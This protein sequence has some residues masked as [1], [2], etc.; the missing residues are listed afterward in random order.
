MKIL[1]TLLAFVV[2]LSV[3]AQ[4]CATFKECLDKGYNASGDTAVDYFEKAIKLSKKTA[5]DQSRAYDG[6]ARV[7]Y[8]KWYGKKDKKN[9]SAAIKNFEKAIKLNPKNYRANSWLTA[10]YQTKLKD[11]NLA[12]KTANMAIKEM[13]NNAN[14]Y[15]NIAHV[16][17]YFNKPD[18]AY[19]AFIK[20]KDVLIDTKESGDY[21]ASDIEDILLWAVYMQPRKAKRNYYTQVEVTE[22]EKYIDIAPKSAKL[23]GELALANYDMGNLEEATTTGNRAHVLDGEKSGDKAFSAT[24]TGGLFIKGLEDF[25]AKRYKDAAFRMSAALD[26][27]KNNHVLFPYYRAVT[28]FFYTVENYPKRWKD[29]KGLTIRQFEQTLK[30]APGTPHEN[31][32]AD[33]NYYLDLINNP[34]SKIAAPKNWAKDFEEFKI[35]FSPLPASYTLNY[36]TLQGRNISSLAATK[37]LANGQEI[38]AIGLLCQ[39]AGGYAF[40]YQS[41]TRSR[42]SDRSSFWVLKTDANGK[43]ILEKKIA[44]TQKDMGKLTIKGSFTLTTS[45]SGY[46]INGTDTYANGHTNSA[47]SSG[48]CN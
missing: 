42:N 30:N 14:V 34:K 26:K 21:T 23:W 27:D 19:T 43:K 41:R 15:H 8:K 47:S 22:L 11:E 2:V 9:T 48:S 20:A 38:N 17:R 46:T 13:P 39:G 33:A 44:H 36:N 25:K 1:F 35:N 18:Q 6:L 31:L 32:V 7:F 10:F 3:Q 28:N 12:L 4:N 24:S 16:Y 45:A 29:I 40:L 5:E 37:E